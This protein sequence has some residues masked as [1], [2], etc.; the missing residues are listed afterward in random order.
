[1]DKYIGK[2][3]DG[4]Y[5][6]A[7]LIGSG[8]M[9]DVYK[10]NDALE[11][12]TVAVKILKEEFCHNAEALRRFKNESKAVAFLS[13][14]NIIKVYDVSFSEKINT[15][16]MEYIDGIT[17]KEYIEQQKAIDW[18]EA[19]FFTVQILRALQYVHDKGIVHRDIKPQ[20]IM[21]KADG[22][23]KITDFGIAQFARSD[24]HTIT[25]R[26]IGSVHYIS[27]EQAKGDVTDERTDLYSVGV[28]LFEMLT[29]Q[30]PFE[31]DSPV[32]V[33]LK[34]IELQPKNPR[35]LNPD[36]PEGLEEITIKAMQK[37]AALRYQS[38]AQMLK[39]IEEFKQNP[40]ISFEYK[41]LTS[42]YDD[43]KKYKKAIEGTK[44]GKKEPRKSGAKSGKER[45]GGDRVQVLPV[46][47]GIT[48]AFVIATIAFMLGMFYLSNPFAK[49]PDVTVPNLVGQS[50][51][52]VRNNPANQRFQIEVVD[53]QFNDTYDA[54]I[55]FEQNPKAKRQVKEGSVIQ[56]KVSS[57]ARTIALPTF[58]NEEKNSVFKK[59]TDLGFQYVERPVDHPTIP[60]GYVVSTDPPGG[61]DVPASAQIIVYVSSGP[62]SATVAVPD[63]TG[64]TLEDVQAA[65]D[66]LGLTLGNVTQTEN[67]ADEGTVLSQT[68]E[69][70]TMAD[71]SSPVDLTVSSGPNRSSGSGESASQSGYSR[72]VVISIPLPV[73]MNYQVS[74]RLAMG[75]ND[76]V[77]MAIVPSVTPIWNPAVEGTGAGTV[78]VYLDNRLYQVYGVNF[79]TGAAYLLT[80]NSGSF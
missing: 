52:T 24:V 14:P 65:L 13:H 16:V 35:Q 29:G 59:L 5:E 76:V 39:D 41:Y 70:S 80:D 30:L 72:R 55:I 4:R 61:A 26:A 23:I 66:E 51:E 53:T 3:L 48:A 17:L 38:S 79:D 69:A 62:G 10:A 37:D 7:E 46:L 43:P 1:M 21:L 63:F 34:Q 73:H 11:S 18:K 47:A 44:T 20:N 31:A 8:G 78:Q 57:G 32:S 36:I 22:S 54:G 12:R 50:Y 71:A 19:V 28:M 42:D 33:A 68:P 77:S 56:I 64:M 25:D 2:K 49:V 27:P 15:I 67:D 9:A 60:E 75:G 45:A 74:V 58:T 40:S 6:I